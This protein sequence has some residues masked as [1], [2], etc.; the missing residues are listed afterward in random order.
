MEYR[1][2]SS[3]LMHCGWGLCVSF[4]FFKEGFLLPHTHL[5]SSVHGLP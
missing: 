2:R 1:E 4:Y 5:L 3:V